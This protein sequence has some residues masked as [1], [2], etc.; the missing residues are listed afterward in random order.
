MQNQTCDGSVPGNNT[1]SAGWMDDLGIP[2]EAQ[3]LIEKSISVLELGALQTWKST[4]WLSRWASVLA[5]G[6]MLG[7]CIYGV[8]LAGA[9]AGIKV[10]LLKAGLYQAQPRIAKG[11]FRRAPSMAAS[12][13]RSMT[14]A[15]TETELKELPETSTMQ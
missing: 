4:V 2:S 6:F 3:V 12:R 14:A 13:S 8:L 5:M 9:K 10:I 11:K 15:L 1:D 7:L